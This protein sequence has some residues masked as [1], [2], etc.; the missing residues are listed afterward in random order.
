MAKRKRKP[1]NRSRSRPPAAAT[2]TAERPSSPNDDSPDGRSD[3]NGTE[4]TEPKAPP[5][6]RPASPTRPPAAGPQRTRAE[7]KELARA[8]R[9]AVR[10]RIARAQRRRQLAWIVGI[11]VVVAAGVF[12]FTNRN[13]SNTPS[14]ALPGVLKTKAPWPAN[15]AQSAARATALGLPPEGTT[16][17]EHANLQIFIQG[18]QEPVPAN[19]G[20]SDAG[21]IQSLHTHSDPGVVHIESSESREFT[22]GEFLGVWGVRFT[23]SCLGGYCNDDTNHLQVF[24]NGEEVTDS[25]QDVQ[26]DDQSVIVVTYGTAEQL[27]DPIPSTFDFASVNP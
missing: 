22:L 17:H 11:T 27:P 6:K 8:E 3:P 2:R 1:Q 24:V 5:R 4:R 10:R 26:L 15:A 23:P 20:I 13:D 25:L 19:I 21:A 14:S 12:F 7:K 9:E 16:M 18:K